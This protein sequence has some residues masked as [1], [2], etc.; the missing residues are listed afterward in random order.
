MLRKTKELGIDVVGVSFHVGSGCY[1]ASAYTK[2]VSTA[3]YVYD[4]GLKVGYRFTLLD[5]GGGFPGDK[6]LAITFEDIV[7]VMNAA[8]DEYFPTELGV[9]VISEPGQ[10]F[11]NSSATLAVNVVSKRKIK[12]R[13]AEEQPVWH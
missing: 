7:P 6:T 3:R 2:A 13:S 12:P 10:F 11:V 4:E 9:E 8:L 1:D 5:I